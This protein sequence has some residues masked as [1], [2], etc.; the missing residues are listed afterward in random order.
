MDKSLVSTNQSAK[1]ALN[2]SKSLLKIANTF[3]NKKS[4]SLNFQFWFDTNLTRTQRRAIDSEQSVSIYADDIFGAKMALICFIERLRNS[5]YRNKKALL[6]VESELLKLN[7]KEK[8]QNYDSIYSLEEIRKKVH[9]ELYDE[10]L[11]YDNYDIESLVYLKEKCINLSFLVVNDEYLKYFPNNEVFIFDEIFLPPYEIFNFARQF[12]PNNAKANSNNLLERLKIKNSGADKPFVY[13]IQTFKEEIEFIN[14]IID[15][16]PTNNIVIALPYGNDKVN[17]DLSVEKYYKELSKTLC[18][19]KYFDGIKIKSL[20]N[21]VI[22]TF[23]NVIYLNPDILIIPQ[24]DV[25]KII[26]ENNKIFNTICSCEDQ[27][28]VFQKKGTFK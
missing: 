4:N 23:D 11:V 19:S 6:I 5:Q 12:V 1:V 16:H 14:D 13:A 27:L 26:I 2:K 20:Y 25:S 24:F 8:L 7:I 3:L 17:Y 15:T 21:I 9:T 18:C 10:I 28:H 22:T